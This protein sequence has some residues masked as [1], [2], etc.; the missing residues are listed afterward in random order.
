[1]LQR[2]QAGDEIEFAI[3]HGDT[4][5]HIEG[6]IRERDTYNGDFIRVIVSTPP[7]HHNVLLVADDELGAPFTAYTEYEYDRLGAVLMLTTAIGE[8]EAVIRAR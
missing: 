3:S 6:T 2:L 5:T 4:T 7:H 1:M 8:F